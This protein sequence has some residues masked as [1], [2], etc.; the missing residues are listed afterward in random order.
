MNP[1]DEYD[2]CESDAD[3]FPV[4][5]PH[6]PVLEDPDC[7]GCREEFGAPSNCTDCPYRDHPKAKPIPPP[8]KK[9]GSFCPYCGHDVD[10]SKPTA[11][12]SIALPCGH[13]GPDDAK[14]C[15]DCGVDY[16]IEHD[17]ESDDCNTPECD[18]G[19]WC[20]GFKPAEGSEKKEES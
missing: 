16:T 13:E 8:V 1:E 3:G 7:D 12:L 19:P 2:Q 4:G 6:S 20:S 17:C 14:F 11:P 15:P 10:W 5:S 18:P 9:T